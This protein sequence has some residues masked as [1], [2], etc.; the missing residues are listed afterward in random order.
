MVCKIEIYKT[1][2]E[3]SPFSQ[4]L[5]MVDIQARQRILI[6][7]KRIRL[8]NLGHY[9]IIGVGVSEVKNPRSE[10]RGIFEVARE[11]SVRGK[12]RGM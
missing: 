2:R 8:G 9:K 10:L 3:I 12:P 7:L 11:S 6:R 4:W 1:L 5:D